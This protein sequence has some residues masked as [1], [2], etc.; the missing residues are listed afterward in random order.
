MD[1]SSVGSAAS[2][3]PPRYKRY[4][5][6]VYNVVTF[7]ASLLVLVICV[8]VIVLG[9]MTFQKVK[10]VVD[11]VNSLQRTVD[12]VAK[13]VGNLNFG[14]VIGLVAQIVQGI[15]GLFTSARV[16]TSSSSSRVDTGEEA[17]V[18]SWLLA[19]NYTV[20][21]L[22]SAYQKILLLQQESHDDPAVV[23]I[24]KRLDSGNQD[25]PPKGEEM[26]NFLKR[27]KVLE[28]EQA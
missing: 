24:K 23:E 11:T 14:G 21:Q 25:D 1:P 4:A 17:K 26:I 18:A 28:M 10:S 5:T 9:A 2:R 15:V 7:V 20:P 6:W 19:Q 22:T 3:N 16:V 12:T 13:E 8:A 27:S